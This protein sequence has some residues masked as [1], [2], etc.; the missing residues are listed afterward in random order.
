[1]IVKQRIEKNAVYQYQSLDKPVSI[2]RQSFKPE[3]VYLLVHSVDKGLAKCKVLLIN[4]QPDKLRFKKNQIVYLPI[5]NLS[6][7]DLYPRFFN[8]PRKWVRL[9]SQ[10]VFDS[11]L[12]ILSELSPTLRQEIVTATIID[13]RTIKVGQKWANDAQMLTIEKQWDKYFI[14]KDKY[15]DRQRYTREE[16]AEKLTNQKFRLQKSFDWISLIKTVSFILVP[17]I[18]AAALTGFIKELAEFLKAKK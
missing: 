5:S 8:D 7:P 13:K 15:G 16:L 18:G 12:E 2:K 4:E 14:V 6:E 11:G 1:M 3:Q 17:F 10:S 9:N